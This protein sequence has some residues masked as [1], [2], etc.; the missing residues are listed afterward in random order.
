MELI[1]TGDFNVPSVDWGT[2]TVRENPQYGREVNDMVIDIANSLYLTQTVE[3]PTKGKNILDLVLV[4]SPGLVE[5][6]QSIPG[7]SDHQAVTIKYTARIKINKKPERTIYKYD[8]A[9]KKY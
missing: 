1:L 7:I 8:R 5:D 4:T 3:E 2:H 6:V 9:D